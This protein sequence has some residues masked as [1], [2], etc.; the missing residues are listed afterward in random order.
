M[1]PSHV[2]LLI[3]L[4]AI[5]AGLRGA[6][7]QEQVTSRVTY[8]RPG[9]A[10]PWRG[11]VGQVVEWG[12]TQWAWTDIGDTKGWIPIAVDPIYD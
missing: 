7:A 3:I 8:G 6:R 10:P 12:G 1:K 5:L 9:E 4:L 11:T 2:V